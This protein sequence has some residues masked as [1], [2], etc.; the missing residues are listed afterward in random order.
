MDIIYKDPKDLKD[1]ENNPR[2][3]AEAIEPVMDSIKEFGFLVPVLIT[4]DGKIVAGHTRKAAALRLGLSSIPCICADSLSEE[5]IRAFRLVDNK[6]AEF[7]SWDFEKLAE[8]LDMISDID[9]EAFR[10]P[11]FGSDLQVSDEDFIQGTESVKERKKKSVI[12]PD[13]GREIIL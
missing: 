9:L 13:C 8:E 4:G 5:Q 2:N 3:N 12:C 7:S 11:D 1:Y 6:T 10:F